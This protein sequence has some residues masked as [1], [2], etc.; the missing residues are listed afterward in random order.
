MTP[1]RFRQIRNVFEA[2]LEQQPGAREW[3]LDE[4]CRSDESLRE[5]VVRLLKTQGETLPWLTA[6]ASET[7]R[8]DPCSLEG[9]LIGPYKVLREIGRGGMGVVYLASR[10]DQAFHKQVAIKIVMPV[11]ATARRLRA[12]SG[13][14]R[15]WRRSTIPI[16]RG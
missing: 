4:A 16:S 15:F 3:F 5:E 10:A 14:A 11:S 6:P 9:R 1:E 7:P 2:V 8:T 12:S 13:S